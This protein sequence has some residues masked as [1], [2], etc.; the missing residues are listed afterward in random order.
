MRDAY[1]SICIDRDFRKLFCF[2]FRDRLFE[3]QC[4]PQGF[5]GVATVFTKVL[6]LI[7]SFLCDEDHTVIMYFDVTLIQGD[8]FYLCAEAVN[9][10]AEVA[11]KL[12]FTIHPV[13]SVFTPS[14]SVKFL[15]FIL[16]SEEMSVTLTDAR[17]RNIA[18][19]V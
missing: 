15:G 2:K 12:G 10:T 16:N 9:C 14:K 17:K 18:G 5:R 3:F 6:K 19:N 8:N 4:L 13:K 1:D 11:D 7:L